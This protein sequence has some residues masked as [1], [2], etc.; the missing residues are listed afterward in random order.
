VDDTSVTFGEAVAAVSGFALLLLMFVG[1][2][3]VDLVEIQVPGGPEVTGVG[4][5]IDGWGAFG[6][7]FDFLVFAAALVAIAQAALRVSG[8]LPQLPAAPGLI[9]AAAGAVAVLLIL[10]RL[11]DPPGASDVSRKFGLILSL[12]AACG[13]SFGG[14]TAVAER[15][16]GSPRRLA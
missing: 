10:Y 13:V 1:W 15:P 8:T 6:F 4:D 14:Y 7:P 5:T 3:Q 16:A 12:V 2:F 11:I 9:V